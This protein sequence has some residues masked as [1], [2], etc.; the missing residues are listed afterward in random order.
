MARLFDNAPKPSAAWLQPVKRMP[1]FAAV[2]GGIGVLLLLIAGVWAVQNHGLQRTGVRVHGAVV[3]IVSTV[4][5]DTKRR[6]TVS[7]G[8]RVRFRPVGGYAD[9]EIVGLGTNPPVYKE[10]DSVTVLYPPEHPERGIVDSAHEL[11][12]GP[13]AIGVFGLLFAVVGALLWRARI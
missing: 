2:F 3:G 12:D 9:V 8:P 13:L 11:R 6:K 5:E 4:S 7:Y 10:G 1:L